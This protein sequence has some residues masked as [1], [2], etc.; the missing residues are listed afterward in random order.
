V[1]AVVVMNQNE[2]VNFADQ[3]RWD[4]GDEIRLQSLSFVV[5]VVESLVLQ[6]VAAVAVVRRI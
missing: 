3:N 4:F 6:M 1:A 2:V 5:V